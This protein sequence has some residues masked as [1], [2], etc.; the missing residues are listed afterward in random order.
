MTKHTLRTFRQ[1][2]E[3]Y[4]RNHPGEV[5]AYI[6]EIFDAYAEDANTAI[7]LAS[8]R[9]IAKA[10][11]IDQHLQSALSRRENPLL[12]DVNAIIN[13]LG[14]RLMPEPLDHHPPA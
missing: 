10:K 11:E 14:Y 2:E 9:V 8:L 3:E 7:L 4:F 5:D 13:A 6:G 1:V 12:D